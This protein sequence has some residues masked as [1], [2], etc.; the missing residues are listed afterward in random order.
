MAQFMKLRAQQ[1]DLIVKD[2]FAA[3]Q[4]AEESR[5]AEIKAATQVQ[6]AFRGHVVRKDIRKKSNAAAVI[7]HSFHRFQA[8][9]RVDQ[10]R[11]ERDAQEA[12]KHYDNCATLIQKIYRGHASR[13]F[14][15][16]YKA[17]KEYIQR[18]KEAG[19][20]LQQQNAEH[21]ERQL[22]DTYEQQDAD[23]FNEFKGLT[24]NLH[25]LL[26]T[27]CVPGVYNNPYTGPATAFNRP[28]E[29]HLRET[30]QEMIRTGE[31]SLTT[32]S[33]MAQY[34]DQKQGSGATSRLSARSNRSQGPFKSREEQEASI[35]RSQRKYGSVITSSSYQ[36]EQQRLRD[37]KR[38]SEIARISN[39]PMVTASSPR[40]VPHLVHASGPYN[41][42]VNPMER[43]FDKSKR[44]S[45]KPFVLAM[46]KNK[47]FDDY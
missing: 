14:R 30:T 26:S 33:R 28:V 2:Y 12:R 22:Q 15:H 47:D 46:P 38:A 27:K 1:H 39:K 42:V 4:A 18:V 7:Q 25:H 19:E 40:E 21:F 8:A 3:T 32:K 41:K 23:D 9:A 37:E 13:K 43:T 29:E 31:L 11:A 45:Q 20:R 35:Q 36:D 5:Q 10:L 17:R 34:Q 24:K 6:S 44:V 16:N